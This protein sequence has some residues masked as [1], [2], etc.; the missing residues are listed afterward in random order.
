[1]SVF[2]AIC[3]CFVWPIVAGY[4]WGRCGRCGVRPVAVGDSEEEGLRKFRERHHRDP[5][6]M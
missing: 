5:E 1:M 6:E 2:Y 4:G 3:D